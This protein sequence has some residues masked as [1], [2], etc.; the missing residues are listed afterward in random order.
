MSKTEIIDALHQKDEIIQK[1][2]R[3]IKMLEDRFFELRM[4]FFKMKY[5]DLYEKAAARPA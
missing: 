5:R 3:R 2:S 4:K 1:Q